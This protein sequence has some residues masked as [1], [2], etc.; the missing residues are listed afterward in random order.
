MFCFTVP[1]TTWLLTGFPASLKVV[2]KRF[3]SSYFHQSL[4]LWVQARIPE[5]LYHK[6]VE[7][8]DAEKSEMMVEH[9][10]P[11]VINCQRI[12][13]SDQKCFTQEN[14]RTLMMNLRFE[15]YNITY[16]LVESFTLVLI[17]FNNSRSTFFLLLRHGVESSWSTPQHMVSTVLWLVDT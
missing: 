5:F 3:I 17:F 16:C 7:E 8:Y 4:M 12:K 9:C 11:S 6:I 1:P 15:K 13:M 2:L 14:K 10:D